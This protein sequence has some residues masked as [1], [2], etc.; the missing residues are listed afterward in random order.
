[1]QSASS[2]CCSSSSSGSN[3]RLDMRLLFT[4][5]MSA[6]SCA[7]MLLQLRGDLYSGHRL[8]R[9]SHRRLSGQH[10]TLSSA[11][12]A[13]C[14]A[15]PAPSSL[16]SRMLSSRSADGEGASGQSSSSMAVLPR[17]AL[18][19]ANEPSQPTR[20][21]TAAVSVFSSGRCACTARSRPPVWAAGLWCRHAH[22][23]QCHA[24]EAQ[25]AR[26]MFRTVHLRPFTDGKVSCLCALACATYTTQLCVLSDSEMLDFR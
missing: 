3:D 7:T 16:R 10:R 22:D 8:G 21:P 14:S 23:Y 20:R 15:C 9:S 2:T 26:P 5:S 18:E 12:R 17:D 19:V 24:C 11:L 1:M 25:R 13:S 4:C 6:M